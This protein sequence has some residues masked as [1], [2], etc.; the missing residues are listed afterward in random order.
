[1]HCDSIVKYKILEICRAFCSKN[2]SMDNREERLLN[3]DSANS[4]VL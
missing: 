3:T 2:S 4:D 1:M